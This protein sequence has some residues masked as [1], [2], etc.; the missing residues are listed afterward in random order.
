MWYPRAT[1][2][3]LC[4]LLLQTRKTGNGPDMNEKIVDW[5]I[6]P[7]AYTHSVGPLAGHVLLENF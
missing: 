2:F 7:Q 1:P 5:E 4:L 3:I 6:K